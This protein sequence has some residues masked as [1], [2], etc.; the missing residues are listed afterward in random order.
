MKRAHSQHTAAADGTKAARP[1]KFEGMPY[2]YYESCRINKHANFIVEHSDADFFTWTVYLT[3]DVL[4][5]LDYESVCP[6]LV[7]WSQAAGQDPVIVLSITFPAQFPNAVP[8][9]RIVRPR[10]QYRTGHVTIGGS[11][12]TPMLT[13]S[14]WKPMNVDALISSVVIILK[15]GGALV[16][17]APD[18]HCARPLLD[19]TEQEARDAYT[20][21]VE[22]Y[23]W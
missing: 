2:L 11:I 23:G 14:G 10:F 18:C 8:F 13:A 22:R 7:R 5:A 6:Y 19:Y 15:E 16:Q 4:K 3:Q 1:K 9:V 21:V 20:R 12:C 17:L